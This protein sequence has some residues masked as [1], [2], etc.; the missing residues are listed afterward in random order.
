MFKKLAKVAIPLVVLAVIAALTI[1]LN[2][3][4]S[5]NGLWNVPAA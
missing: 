1:G 5:F 3:D 2:G 4:C